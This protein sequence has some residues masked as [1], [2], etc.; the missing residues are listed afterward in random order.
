[1]TSIKHKTE[2][3]APTVKKN[4]GGYSKEGKC[5]GCSKDGPAV[6]YQNQAMDGALNRIA[7]HT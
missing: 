5:K 6:C 4:E 1:M 7:H 2:K 3:V